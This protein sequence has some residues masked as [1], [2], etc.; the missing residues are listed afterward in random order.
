MKSLKELYVNYE[1]P[2]TEGMS[3]QIHQVSIIYA[4]TFSG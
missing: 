2:L 3:I 4:M 1:M